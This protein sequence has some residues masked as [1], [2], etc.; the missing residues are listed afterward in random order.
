MTKKRTWRNISEVSDLLGMQ[1]H[2]RLLDIWGVSIVL[3]DQTE[4]KAYSELSLLKAKNNKLVE[5]VYNMSAT[6]P[7]FNRHRNPAYI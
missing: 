6:T 5:T 4:A 7:R 1:K 3:Y 2:L